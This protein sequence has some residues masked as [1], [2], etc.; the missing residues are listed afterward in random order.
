M[1]NIRTIFGA[2]VLSA[3]MSLGPASSADAQG[4]PVIDI[5]SLVQA[6]QQVAAWQ[7]QYE[8]MVQQLQQLDQQLRQMNTMTTKLDGGRGLG[9]VLNDPSINTML[10]P[11]MR[12]ANQLMMQ[13]VFTPT[14]LSAIN[15][16]LSAYGVPTSSGT[17]AINVGRSQADGLVKMQ[18]ILASSQQR[19]PQVDAL[20]LRV[21]G[22]TD[23]KESLDL[24]NRNTIEATRVNNQVLQTMA[25]IEANRQAQQLRDI[26]ADQARLS[27]IRARLA[28]EVVN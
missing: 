1:K 16:V 17:T 21:D 10:P 27:A 3:A 4:I 6:M 2:S 18:S 22:S 14:Q 19:Q 11:E 7:Q 15:N 23:A 5:A 13:G 8:Q 26:A 25:T 28:A 20:A 9:S 24:L 12:D